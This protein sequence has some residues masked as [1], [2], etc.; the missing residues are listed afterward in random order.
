MRRKIVAF[1]LCFFLRGSMLLA[2]LPASFTQDDEAFLALVERRAFDYFAQEH[3]TRTGLVKDKASNFGGDR[4][5]VASIAATGFGLSAMCVGAE[6]GWISKEEARRY[7][8]RTLRFFL[9]RMDHVHGFFYHFVH[10]GTGKR[11]NHSELSSIDTALFLAGALTAAEYFKGTEV[12]ELANDLYERVDFPWMLNG[13]TTLSMGWDPATGFLRPRWDRY[14]EALMLYVLAVG[15]PTHPIPS[16]SW[17]GVSKK[18]GLYGDHVLIAC[19]PLF[20]HQYSAI[21]LDLRDKNDGFADYFENSRAATLA[22]R[23]FCLDQRNKYKTYSEDIWGLTASDGPNGYRAYGAEPGGA[24]HDGTVAPT[25]A[26]GSIVFTPEISL[27]ALRSMYQNHRERLWGKYGFSDAFN[28]DQNW[29]SSDVLGIDQGPMLLMIE[30]LRSEFVWRVFMDHPAIERGMGLLGFRAGTLKLTVPPAP[31]VA[32]RPLDRKIKIDGDLRD[33]KLTDPIRLKPSEHL[34]LGHING[35]RDASGRVYLA[36]TKRHLYLA[37]RIRDDSLIMKRAKDKIWR[38]D[39]LELFVDPAGDGLKWSDPKDVQLGMS[40]GEWENE[41]RSW[42]WFQGY[43]PSERKLL[44]LRILRKV[45][46][47]DLE[48]RV[49]WRLLRIDPREGVSFGLSPALHDLDLDGSE[50]KLNGYFLA[51]GKTGRVLLG[52]AVLE[53]R[54]FTSSV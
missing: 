36:W 51:N 18:I 44:K 23:E 30:N 15:S 27:R 2:A 40:P 33:W 43:D 5:T 13:G 54:G 24:V 53:E 17:R 9:Q 11:T 42:A 48:A 35:R 4:Y 39:C 20:T 1:L 38:D 10:W 7:C 16:E 6:R 45:G 8:S 37:A 14:N 19:P 12:E 25:A 21:W 41:G 32:I 3:H 34:E 22:N 28:L 46:G 50:G 47:Y 49:A 31:R 52:K 29:F 26:G